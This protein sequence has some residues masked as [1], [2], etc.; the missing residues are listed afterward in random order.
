MT[1]VSGVGEV[2]VLGTDLAPVREF[3][4]DLL[5]LEPVE[6]EGEHALHR[7]LGGVRFL[8]LAVASEPAAVVRLG[9][10]ATIGCDP[11]TDDL[12]GLC[13]QQEEAGVRFSRAYDGRSAHVLDPDGNVLELPQAR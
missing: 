9:R 6:Q 1:P 12:A 11:F 8:L 5:G 7:E 2:D 10:R 13:R 4:C 3:Y